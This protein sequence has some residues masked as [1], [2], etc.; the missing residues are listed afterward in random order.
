MSGVPPALAADFELFNDFLDPAEATAAFDA[1]FSETS[2]ETHHF[3]IFGK[4]IEMP[5]RIA[6]AGLYDYQYSGVHHRAVSMTEVVSD[7]RL[8][9]SALSGIPFNVVL[10]NLYRDGAD[11]M[12]WHADDDYENGGFPHVAS[13][14]LGEPRRFAVRRRE[15]G[16]ESHRFM[17]PHG[18]L[19]MMRA[20]AQARWQHALPKMKRVIKPRINLTFRHMATA[21]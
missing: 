20:N 10:I 6:Y 17:L 7:L 13:V 5:R 21:P 19:L 2:W 16:R 15:G 9:I 4:V 8:R 18:S 14:S 12:G 1:I 11:S 3:K